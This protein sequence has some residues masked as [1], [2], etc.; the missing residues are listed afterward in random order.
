MIR[1]G[2][3]L[4]VAIAL[5]GCD[6]RMPDYRYKI[7]IK[8]QGK[9][10]SSV[11]QIRQRE[12][13]S[14]QDSS[15]RRVETKINGQAVIMDLPN[16]SRVYATLVGKN[17]P[18]QAK[19]AADVALLP[20][21]YQRPRSAKMLD[22]IAA[23]QQIIAHATGVHDLPRTVSHN[24]SHRSDYVPQATW[25]L[26]A[27]F[28]DP[29]DW[30]TIHTVDPEEIGVSRITIEITNDP[31]TTGIENII[32]KP[33]DGPRFRQWLSSLPYNDD[34]ISIISGFFDREAE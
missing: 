26:F 22:A 34:R 29:N 1:F 33:E 4:V 24:P 14:I 12:A 27:T 16:G 6:E 23:E 10:Y 15:G 11:R 18:Q 3:L 30:T 32:T 25:P 8:A 13:F 7:T 31:V 19:Y 28:R 17:S 2:W 5:V 20:K 21:D 9:T